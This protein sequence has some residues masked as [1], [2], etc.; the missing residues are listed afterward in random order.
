ME[1]RDEHERRIL[2]QL[3]SRRPV[4]QRSLASDL[5]IALGLTNLLMRRLVKKGWVRVTHVS[6]RRIR[7]L[8]TPAGIAAKA[9][10]TRQYFLS[11]LSFYRECREHVCDRLAVLSTELEARTGHADSADWIVFYG[12]GE[13]AEVV[14][15]CLQETDLKLLGIVDEKSGR[16]FFQYA[17]H[18]PTELAG[19]TLAGRPFSMLV[20]MPSDQETEVR[21]T[22]ALRDVP[23]DRVFWL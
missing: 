7:Y 12:A 13:V 8:I 1:T 14:Y 9:R 5:G 19:D 11:S 21:R 23:A 3:E 2:D 10:L 15:V 20:V 16:G 4:T 17:V 6:P 18:R 22:L